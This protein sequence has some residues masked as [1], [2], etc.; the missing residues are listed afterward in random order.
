MTLC[1]M[2]YFINSALCKAIVCIVGKE[3]KEKLTA[4]MYRGMTD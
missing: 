1:V 3:E 4:K 2:M